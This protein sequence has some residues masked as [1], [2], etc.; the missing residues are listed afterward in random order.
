[1]TGLF[2]RLNRTA[3]SG[4]R[5][6]GGVSRP[7]R[8][9]VSHYILNCRSGGSVFN[10]SSGGGQANKGCGC[11]W[12][13]KPSTPRLHHRFSAT[14]WWTRERVGRKVDAGYHRCGVDLFPA[15]HVCLFIHTAGICGCLM[16]AAC[17]K[18]PRRLCRF[19]DHLKLDIIWTFLFGY[20]CGFRWIYHDFALFCLRY[21]PILIGTIVPYIQKK[22][23]VIDVV[24]LG[25]FCYFSAAFWQLIDFLSLKKGFSSNSIRKL[26]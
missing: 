12:I 1:M 9:F 11:R 19:S 10:R 2:H 25:G 16:C 5:C 15:S 3:F 24:I 4:F 20:L 26:P 13:C 23:G 6:V 17:G 21:V 18:K 8:G 22:K 14:A 7:G